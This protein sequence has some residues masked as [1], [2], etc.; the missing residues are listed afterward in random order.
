MYVGT[1][2][3]TYVH[4]ISMLATPFHGMHVPIPVVRNSQNLLPAIQQA[5]LLLVRVQRMECEVHLEPLSRAYSDA[6]HKTQRKGVRNSNF[7][8][9]ILFNTFSLQPE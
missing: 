4:C 9:C 1:Y 8:L 2:V 7:E 3:C 5:L 6:R